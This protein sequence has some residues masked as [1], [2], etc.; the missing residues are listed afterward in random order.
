MQFGFVTSAVV[1][2][3]LINFSDASDESVAFVDAGDHAY[4]IFT[5]TL[6]EPGSQIYRFVRTG[7]DEFHVYGWRSGVNPFAG[8]DDPPHYVR[9]ISGIPEK[10]LK[11]MNEVRE[12]WALN[13]NYQS[14]LRSCSHL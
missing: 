6:I 13:D 3:T 14:A 4:L 8:E 11:R 5:D 1:R 10:W 12:H 7:S 2:Q 9:N